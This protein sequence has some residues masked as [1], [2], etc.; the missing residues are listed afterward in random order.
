MNLQI[1]EP[2]SPSFQQPLALLSD[3]HRRVERFL[4]LIARVAA[5]GRGGFLDRRQREAL[6]AAL[7][8][9]REAAPRHTADEEESLFPRLRALNSPVAREIMARM[10]ALERDHAE[11]NPHHLAVEGLGTRWLAEGVLSEA[12]IRALSRHIDHLVALYTVHIGI[13]D[14]VVFPAA[15]RLLEPT[16]L[17]EVGQEMAARRGQPFVPA[18]FASP[19][20]DREPQSHHASA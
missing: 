11:A 5:E 6:E 3:C 20:A 8:Y 4:G 15:G 1:G 18:G 12:D 2:S 16:S 7:R 17:A 14:H 9:F 19:N 13:E 10:V